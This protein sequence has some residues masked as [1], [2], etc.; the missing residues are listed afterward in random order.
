MALLR[1]LPL[2][3]RVRMSTRGKPASWFSAEYG[4]KRK[5]ISAICDF[6]GSRPPEKPLTRMT[7]PGPAM[8]A[9][10]SA[11][12]SSSSGRASIWSC[13]SADE[14]LSVMFWSVL[15]RVTSTSS[16]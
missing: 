15:S 13:V 1:Q 14:K 6:G 12:S 11:I 9:S 8:F 7:A 10:C 5:R 2:P 3:G 4:S 16:T